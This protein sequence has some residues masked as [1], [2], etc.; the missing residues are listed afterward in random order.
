MT[1]RDIINLLNPFKWAWWNQNE[2]IKQDRY[3][4]Y[5]IIQGNEGCSWDVELF[6]IEH[7]KHKYSCEDRVKIDKDT[8]LNKTVFKHP[9]DKFDMENIERVDVYEGPRYE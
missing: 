7:Y 8:C 9:S 6:I 2:W 4:V 3:I 1:I 5:E